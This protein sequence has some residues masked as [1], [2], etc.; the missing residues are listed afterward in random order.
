[1]VNNSWWLESDKENLTMCNRSI[2]SKSNRTFSNFNSYCWEIDN[3]S[4]WVTLLGG[5]RISTNMASSVGSGPIYSLSHMYI[6]HC[7]KSIVGSF[8]TRYD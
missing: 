5:V 8:S 1:M 2:K 3:N 4:R 6:S 7:G